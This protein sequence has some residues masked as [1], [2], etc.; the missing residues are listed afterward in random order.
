MTISI[1]GRGL[2]M[3]NHAQVNMRSWGVNKDETYN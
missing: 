3:T 1:G 2:M